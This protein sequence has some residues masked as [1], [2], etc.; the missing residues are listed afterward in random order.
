M[1]KADFLEERAP[2]RFLRLRRGKNFDR[3]KMDE[4]H[5]R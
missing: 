3:S 1:E 2:A 4:K 5:V